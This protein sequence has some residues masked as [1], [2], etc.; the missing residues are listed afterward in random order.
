MDEAQASEL[1]AALLDIA[2]V[3]DAAVD[4]VEGMAYLKIDPQV[5]DLTKL[6]QFAEVS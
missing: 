4:E 6:D 3:A 5:I 1:R 2:G